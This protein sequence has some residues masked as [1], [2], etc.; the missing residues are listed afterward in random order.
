MFIYIYI[1]ILHLKTRIQKFPRYGKLW[2]AGSVRL[3]D[4]KYLKKG[5]QLSDY[6]MRLGKGVLSFLSGT[7]SASHFG[8]EIYWDETKKEFL[9]SEPFSFWGNFIYSYIYSIQLY[10]FD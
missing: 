10:L 4:M 7:E 3:I 5:A 1:L 2:Q 8:N 6:D 9:I